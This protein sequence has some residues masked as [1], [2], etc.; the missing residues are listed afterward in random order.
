MNKWS[1]EPNVAPIRLHGV[2]NITQL[3]ASFY[4]RLIVSRDTRIA[5]GAIYGDEK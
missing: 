4:W 2:L 1:K 5:L 3:T